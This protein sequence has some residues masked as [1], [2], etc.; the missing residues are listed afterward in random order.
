MNLFRLAPAVLALSLALPAAHAGDFD[1]YE[2]LQALI[3]GLEK[4]GVYPPGELTALFT[5]VNRQDKVVE[6]MSR[7]AEKTREWRNYRPNFVNDERIRKG[8]DFWS[9]YE[10]ELN[11]ASAR[12]GVPPELIVAI[13]GVET[14][15]G[16]N[17]GSHR[18]IESL[19][20]LAFGYPARAP[21]FRRE[22]RAFLMLAK[23]QGLDPLD[24]YGS[25]AGAMGF[26]QFMPSSWRNLAIDYS[27]DGKIDLINDPVDAIGSVAHYFLSHGWKTGEPVAV[28]ARIE[29]DVY[30]EALSVDLKT[31]APLSELAAKGLSPR[32]GNLPPDFPAAAIRLQGENGAE[33]WLVF[34]NFFAITRYNRSYNY[35]MA[36][37]QLSEALRAGRQPPPN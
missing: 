33:F 12:F 7:P 28:R 23:E 10:T 14:K 32:D 30:D 26:P 25:Y 21:F 17:K 37:F 36:V 29:G 4:D 24:T 27:G 16:G 31:A 11:A 6:A 35:A 18:I 8:L 2:E 13:I 19:S 20:S 22:L 1:Q 15:Y 9:K 3:A 5:S 34:N